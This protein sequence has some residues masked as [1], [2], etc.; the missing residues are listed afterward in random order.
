MK[1]QIVTTLVL[2]IS[3][4]YSKAVP[5]NPT[6][7]GDNNDPDSDEPNQDTGLFYH[8]YLMKVM[9]ALETDPSF[10]EQILNYDF[11]QIKNGQVKIDMENISDE[12]RL[13]LDDVKRKEVDRIRHLIRAQQD[14]EKGQ[15]ITKNGMKAYLNDI[16]A[17]F[18]H[19][20]P[21]SF[22]EDDVIKLISSAAKDMDEYDADRHDKFKKYEMHQKLQEEARLAG[23]SEEAR[24]M[25]EKRIK[26]ERKKHKDH[27][28]V[29]HPGSK[30]QF[31]EVWN[32]EDEM[33]DEEFNPKT[34]FMMHDKNSD[35][36]LDVYEVELLMEHELKKVYDPENE[37]DDMVEMEEE[38]L[39]MRQHFF[40]EVDKNQDKMISL[41][42]FMDYTNTKEYEKPDMRSYETVDE[43]IDRG[44]VYTKA[45][46]EEYKGEIEEQERL[47]KDKIE[48]MRK[49]SRSVMEYKRDLTAE[50]IAHNKK[51]AQEITD[52]DR[53]KIEIMEKNLN[54]KQSVLQDMANDVQNIAKDLTDMK[55]DYASNLISTDEYQLKIKEMEKKQADKL[56]QAEQKMESLMETSKVAQK[57]KEF[58]KKKLEMEEKLAQMKH[59]L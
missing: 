13:H 32:E 35:N 30:K 55:N 5:K 6:G 54:E 28:L 29:N 1:L 4:I 19:E 53:L 12:M 20:T 57:I 42:E 56:A 22:T 51:P 27:D 26:E 31:E 47:L 18:D 21:H 46:L 16:A 40:G 48:N 15:K 49:H 11:E 10:R 14:L 45:D 2:Q 33:V 24:D 50:Q 37:E 23:L 43:S 8:E 52:E 44:K 7:K 36:Y 38:R 59:Q 25:E 34:F 58:E 41:K 39:R 17:H 3:I 9:K